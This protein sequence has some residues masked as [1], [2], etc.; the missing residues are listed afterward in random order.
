MRACVCTEQYMPE[1]RLFD[2]K[3]LIFLLLLFA[4]D[5]YV[6]W[7]AVAHTSKTLIET[8]LN[9]GFSYRLLDF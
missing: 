8:N 6:L 7:C 2:R 4:L 1:D 9:R 5:M 3:K